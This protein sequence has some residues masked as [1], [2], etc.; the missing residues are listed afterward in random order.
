MEVRRVEHG[1]DVRGRVLELAERTPEDEG[2]P[3]GGPSQPEEH[4]ERRRLA[5]PVRTEKP[6]D[7]ARVDLEGE[8]ADRD[9]VAVALRQRAR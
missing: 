6:G 3:F 9:D 5:C 7:A 4:P 2:L 8:I 1:A